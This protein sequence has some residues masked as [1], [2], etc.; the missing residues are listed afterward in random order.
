MPRHPGSATLKPD[1]KGGFTTRLELTWPDGRVRQH[2]LTAPTK[3]ALRELADA[4]IRERDAAAAPT[5][6]ELSTIGA[7]IDTYLVER[8]HPATFLSGVKVSGV[9]NHK[10]RKRLCEVVRSH[11]G[12]NWLVRAVGPAEVEAYKSARIAHQDQNDNTRKIATINHELEILRALLNFAVSRHIITESPFKRLRGIIQN[13][14]EDKRDRVPTFGEE[15]AMLDACYTAGNV[16]R[17]YFRSV[18]I[19]LADTG[20][21]RGELLKLEKAWCDFEARSISLPRQITKTNKARTIPMTARVA[22]E[23]R[24]LIATK[25]KGSHLVLGGLKNI[26]VIFDHVRKAAGVADIRIHDMRHATVTRAII[27][28]VPLAAIT[29]A[30]GHQSDEWRRYANPSYDG[31]K[32]LLRPFGSQTEAEVKEYARGVLYGIKEAFGYDLDALLK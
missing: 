15:M 13:S 7:L 3:R 14:D 20:M 1:G 21:R 18:L 4:K 5:Q 8:A 6:I 2:K 29:A 30:S 26:S 9:K 11:F 24:N 31:L 27:A 12:A 16:R 17:A 22:G 32:T 25:G 28:G 19:I 10:E 23:L